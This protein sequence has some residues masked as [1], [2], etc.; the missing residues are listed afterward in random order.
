MSNSVKYTLC[1]ENIW[2]L[3]EALYTN[4]GLTIKPLDVLFILNQNDSIA[5]F[6]QNLCVGANPVIWDYHVV[7]VAKK[8]NAI[9][10]F[11]F[12]SR[13]SF[14]EKI[15]DYFYRSLPMN[16][17]LAE[18]YRA[19]LKPIKAEFFYQHFYSSR[20]HMRGIINDSEF[21]EYGIIRPDDSI[22]R[23]TLDECRNTDNASNT[24]NTISNELVP[25][26]RYLKLIQTRY[27]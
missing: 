19:L 21:P 17:T 27:R 20:Q 10:L 22:D 23:L 6:E 24:L 26:D 1:E 4:Q 8:D 18:T 2:K 3:I 11:D 12:D 7:L 14:P 16:I 25:P 15:A 13:C 5:L 9:V